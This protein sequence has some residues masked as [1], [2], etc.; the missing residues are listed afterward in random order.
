MKNGL[1]F[2]RSLFGAAPLRV[3]PRLEPH[4]PAQ[5][6]TARPRPKCSTYQQVTHTHIHTDRE[7]HP[8][9]RH[10][11]AHDKNN[12]PNPQTNASH[13]HLTTLEGGA[14]VRFGLTR[15]Q[16]GLLFTRSLFG[17]GPARSTAL[18]SPVS[19]CASSP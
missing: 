1:L 4:S 8:R 6:A 18:A 19:H 5:S 7:L 3:R 15:M 9:H 14:R 12:T 2:T 11:H 17:G 16:D 10:T 13:K